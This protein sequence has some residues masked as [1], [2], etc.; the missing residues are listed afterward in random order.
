MWQL[1]L[2]GLVV[3]LGAAAAPGPVNVEIVR[4]ALSYGPRIGAA[5]A[6]GA[7]SADLIFLIA[8]SR[9]AEALATTLPIQ[10][11]IA[12]YLAG[13]VVLMIIGVKV[14]RAKP[15]QEIVAETKLEAKVRRVESSQSAIRSYLIGLALAVS[16]PTTIVYWSGVCITAA[17]RVEEGTPITKPLATGV[18]TGCLL[19]IGVV[20]YLAAR[21]H[22]R[23]HPRTYLVV[24]RALGAALILFSVLSAY[25]AARL[26][27]P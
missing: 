21:F 24:E 22:R 5:F 14:L 17:R 11:K 15:D 1:Y 7:V 27:L 23:I 6:L 16:S 10:G 3:G 2:W 9:G 20:V 26:M 25:Q 19:Y 13:A 4:R 8:I 18:A 12:M